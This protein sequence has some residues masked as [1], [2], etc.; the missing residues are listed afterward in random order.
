M[1]PT[2]QNDKSLT[3]D[4]NTSNLG[5]KDGIKGESIFQMIQIKD[6]IFLVLRCFRKQ[7]EGASSPLS[8]FCSVSDPIQARHA[9]AV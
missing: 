5:A 3:S 6:I 7:G 8:A 1:K 2:Q 4:I 9:D